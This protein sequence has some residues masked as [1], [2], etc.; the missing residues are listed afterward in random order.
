VLSLFQV[1]DLPLCAAHDLDR[2]CEPQP[3]PCGARQVPGG[4][5][6]D[7]A[8]AAGYKRPLAPAH[9]HLQAVRR[10]DAATGNL[11][12]AAVVRGPQAVSCGKE[13]TIVGLL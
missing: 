13:H 9:R 12:S 5:G 8:A 10:A 4:G 6:Q 2:G 7:Y 1:A 3:L 11:A